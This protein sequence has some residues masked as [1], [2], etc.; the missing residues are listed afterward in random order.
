MERCRTIY[1]AL[2]YSFL[3]TMYAIHYFCRNIMT[4]YRCKCTLIVS[5]QKLLA[6]EISPNK[7]SYYAVVIL[8]WSA[9]TFN[10]VIEHYP[11]LR[12]APTLHQAVKNRQIAFTCT[13]EAEKSEERARFEVTWFEG[14]PVKRINKTN[15]LNGL[16]RNA[17]LQ[18]GFG[19]VPL[20]S[21]GKVVS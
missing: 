15:L 19:S 17:T 21:L 16:A 18:N 11:K 14:S 10:S 8:K 12:T 3:T 2:V 4:F 7:F 6:K 9:N 13:F 20:F 1:V 5:N